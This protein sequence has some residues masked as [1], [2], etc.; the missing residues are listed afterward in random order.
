MIGP[1]L[2]SR[3]LCRVFVFL[4]IARLPR[5]QDRFRWFKASL[6]TIWFAHSRILN[7]MTKY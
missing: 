2:V 5:G 4:A 1:F 7:R 3:A 6:E